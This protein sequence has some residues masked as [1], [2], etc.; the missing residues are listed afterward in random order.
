[1]TLMKY[2]MY[3]QKIPLEVILSVNLSIRS[4]T[5]ELGIVTTAVVGLAKSDSVNPLLK[6]L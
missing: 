2:K 4:V 5:E 1:M 6:I 3:I